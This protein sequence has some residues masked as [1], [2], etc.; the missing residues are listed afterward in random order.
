LYKLS[1]LYI[2]WFLIGFLYT[3][4]AQT[5]SVPLS[6]WV[7]DALDRWE[8]RGIIKS[9]MNGS[10]PF[11]RREIAEY[12]SQVVE[13][14]RKNPQNFSKTE[15]EQLKY[16]LVDF[17]EDI[18]DLIELL[19]TEKI[20]PRLRKIVDRKPFITLGKYVYK[21]SR[22]FLVIQQDDFNLFA[23]PIFNIDSQDMFALEQGKFNQTRWSN[24]LQSWGN[25]GKHLGFFFNL[26]DNHVKDQRWK[27]EEITFQVLE[28]SGWPYLTKTGKGA[29]DYNENVAY[30]TFSH[31]FV[32]FLFG[33]EYNE[34]GVGY[35]GKLL[36]ST[37]SQLYDQ[38][39]LVLRYW[40]FKLTHLTAFLQYISP[41]ARTYMKDQPYINTYWSGNR[42][43]LNAG[44]GL[45]LGISEAVVYGDRSLQLGYLNPLAFFKSLE[46]FYGDRDNGLISLDFQWRIFSG[47]K[48]YGEWLIDDLTSSKLGSKFY[49]NKFGWQTGM[50]IVNPLG[51]ND[52]DFLLEYARIK[53]YVYSQSY[54]DYNKYK[55]YDT[56]LG[57]YIGPNSDNLYV[58]LR[59][60]FSKHC[61]FTI[62]YQKYRHGSNLPE[63]N[64]GGD[65]DRPWM[66][67]DARDVKFL[68]GIQVKQTV[69]GF[70]IK[71]EF[72]RNFFG[73]FLYR[74]S[75]YTPPD[76][77]SFFSAR[78]SFNFGY[79]N[80]SF[81]NV[82][83]VTY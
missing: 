8:V 19:P 56:I 54:K 14:Y 71:Y 3:L 1:K 30:L 11:T 75:Q 60:N 82:F 18:S 45:K 12:I 78:L 25:L 66:P 81:K 64:V 55:H 48:I 69:L 6:H 33:R 22:N 52:V 24:G 47:L 21:N 42:L 65:P 16:L 43:D 5:V 37:N 17:Q 57:H 73:E 20:V 32:Y 58:R 72:F 50:V 15:Q 9:V 77:K 62:L 36:L 59:K 35:H 83:P 74:Y 41:E 79:R 13:N 10:K 31:K 51:I 70:S 39:K 27:N 38:L 49:G 34:W 44:K 26:T 63:R 67:E 68:E 23:D 76:W 29:W 28:E 61:Q 40:R 2:F 4:F 7:Y 80:E 46:H 53:P